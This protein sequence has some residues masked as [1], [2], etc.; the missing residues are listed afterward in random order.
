MDDVGPVTCAG[1]GLLCD[2]VTLAGVG[3]GAGAGGG[4]PVR[5][6]PPCPLGA[7]WFSARIRTPPETAA[8]IDGQAADLESAVAHAAGLLRRARR[9][10]VYGF[11]DATVEDARA[12]VALADRL[13]ALI[14]AEELGGPWPGAPAGALRGTSTATLGEIRDRS[15]LLVIWREDPQTTHPRLLTRLGAGQDGAAT[16]FVVDDRDTATAARADRRLR[17]PPEHDLTA[18]V[19]LHALHQ[20]LAVPSGEFDE[21]LRE[22]LDALHGVPHAAIVHGAGLTGGASAG[23]ERRGLAL[24]ELVRALGHDRHVVTLALSRAAGT[25]GAR[26][27]LSWQT[28]YGSGTVDLA[29]GYPELVSGTRAATEMGVDV[30]VRVQSGG[31]P[32]WPADVTEI[33]LGGARPS[34]G[35]G[36]AVW[37]R[38]AAAGV[39]AGGTAHRL[40]GV[41]LTLQAPAPRDVPTAASVLT[42]LLAGVAG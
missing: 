19:T 11:D 22:L 23:G 21:Q 10:L 13:G 15:R 32:A 3:A 17:W 33:S 26:D 25:T 29:A 14:T 39:E 34:S 18:L 12:A 4:E 31:G 8:T 37:V 41:P 5:L 38:T 16:L 35:P 42:R 1:C 2:D 9:P 28:G 40:D 36:P 7:E 27:A 30:V 6:D 24:H 20:G